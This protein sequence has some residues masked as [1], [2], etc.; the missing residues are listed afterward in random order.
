MHLTKH[1]YCHWAAERLPNRRFGAKVGSVHWDTTERLF[2][3]TADGREF[4]A[5]NV[6]LGGGTEP[7][8]RTAFTAPADHPRV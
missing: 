1:H 4:A 3:V 5:R 8:R 6:V 7:Y 2:E